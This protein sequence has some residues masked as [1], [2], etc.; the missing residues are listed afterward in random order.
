MIKFTSGKKLIKLTAILSALVLLVLSLASCGGGNG[1]EI[2][3]ISQSGNKLTVSGKIGNEVFAGK[4]G[5]IYLFA[6]ADGSI[7]EGAEPVAE[8]EA[9]SSFKFTVDCAENSAAVFAGYTV[10]ALSGEGGYVPL[11]PSAYVVPE[12]KN[13]EPENPAASK[14]GILSCSAAT[15]SD[16]AC[17]NLVYEIS[18]PDLFTGEGED[19]ISY[20]FGGRDYY[21]SKDKIKNLKDTLTA[22]EEN[23]INFILNPV[24]YVSGNAQ[25]DGASIIIEGAPAGGYSAPDFAKTDSAAAYEAA[26]SF[27]A[28]ETGERINSAVAGRYADVA[29]ECNYGI[30]RNAL[31]LAKS[32]ASCAR[33]VYTAFVRQNKNFRVYIP[34]SHDFADARGDSVSVKATLAKVAEIIPDGVNWRGAFELSPSSTEVTNILDDNLCAENENAKYISAKNIQVLKD[35]LSE[36]GAPDRFM[37]FGCDMNMPTASDNSNALASVVYTYLT[38]ENDENADALIYTSLCDGKNSAGLCSRSESGIVTEKPAYA[39]YKYV[40]SDSSDGMSTSEAVI[41]QSQGKLGYTLSERFPNIDENKIAV[42]SLTEVIA[43]NGEPLKGKKADGEKIAQGALLTGGAYGMKEN[44]E[45]TVAFSISPDAKELSGITLDS[46]FFGE[47]VTSLSFNVKPTGNDGGVAGITVIISGNGGREIFESTA[48]TSAGASL[49]FNVNA[50]EFADKCKGDTDTVTIAIKPGSGITG[51]EISSLS[52]NSKGGGSGFVAFLIGLILICILLFI[53][54]AGGV[55]NRLFRN[56]K[57]ERFL[58][59]LDKKTNTQNGARKN[60]GRQ[61]PQSQ[62]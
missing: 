17:G 16:L 1:S 8:T 50:K 62:R 44:G 49:T 7:P 22:C 39:T 56:K 36:I 33:I 20:S 24:V 41:S 25:G 9:S 34:F 59:L 21:F 14:K 23:G 48:E 27:I 19:A 37:I 45:D 4:K 61:N 5:R 6:T 32:A 11:A 42:H 47:K 12:G 40:D 13:E 2:S 52:I 46:S 26:I 43:G 3:G 18:L 58:A 15:A 31:D 35:Y 54:Y 53:V 57:V 51:A 28:S 29:G 55:R 10:A 30:S 60:A 38:A